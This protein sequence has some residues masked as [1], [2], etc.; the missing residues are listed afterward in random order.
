MGLSLPVF[1]QAESDVVGYEVL[2]LQAGFNF[3]GLRLHEKPVTSGE[4][5]SV[6]DT[7]L[8]IL[9]KISILC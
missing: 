1:G 6:S 3:I 5:S 8:K 4:L 9:A 2:D 7:L